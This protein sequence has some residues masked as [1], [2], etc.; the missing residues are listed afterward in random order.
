MNNVDI[1][2]CC[3]TV[4]PEGMMVCIECQNKYNTYEKQDIVEFVEEMCGAKL[5]WYQK[6]LLKLYEKSFKHTRKGTK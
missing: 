6:F 4:I 3:G 5:Y 1:C 2:V